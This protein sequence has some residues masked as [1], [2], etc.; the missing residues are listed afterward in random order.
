MT[1]VPVNTAE[2]VA[3]RWLADGFGK[4]DGA[5]AWMGERY[6]WTVRFEHKSHEDLLFIYGRNR[7][8]YTVRK[9]DWVIALGTNGSLRVCSD[10]QFKQDYREASK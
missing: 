5:I 6:G 8:K 2:F 10:R 3:V 9:G 1:V 7:K 4:S